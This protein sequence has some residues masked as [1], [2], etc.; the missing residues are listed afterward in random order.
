VNI[1]HDIC[2]T[3]TAAPSCYPWIDRPQRLHSVLHTKSSPGP[4]KVFI[5]D[6][7]RRTTA[8]GLPIDW[9]TSR[10]AIKNAS[11]H[12][13]TAQQKVYLAIMS[14][15]WLPS[16]LRT[17]PT[18]RRTTFSCAPQPSHV[19]DFCFFHVVQI[20]SSSSTTTADP[21]PFYLHS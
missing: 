4:G 10:R 21:G 19:V 2:Q 13:V 6:S 16:F 14:F 8:A 5:V 15:C 18:T 9:Y 20:S 11:L 1:W 3:T 17:E 12:W 7:A